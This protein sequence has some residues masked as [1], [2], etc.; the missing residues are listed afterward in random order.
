MKT[1]EATVE[2]WKK[3]QDDWYMYIYM[4]KWYNTRHI[5][6]HYVKYVLAG[7][8]VLI[9]IYL[10]GGSE[11]CPSQTLRLWGIKIKICTWQLCRYWHWQK[12]F[13]NNNQIQA[14]R[15]LIYHRY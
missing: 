4:Y 14:L 8:K 9:F 10:F 6:A 7:C 3:C 1:M 12:R 11:C 15:K 5:V 2:V 13:L